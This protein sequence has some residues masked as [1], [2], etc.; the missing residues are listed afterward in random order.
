VQ[1]DIE[2]IHWKEQQWAESFLTWR[3]KPSTQGRRWAEALPRRDTMFEVC[4]FEEPIIVI[5]MHTK[6]QGFW[7]IVSTNI[8]IPTYIKTWDC[9]AVNTMHPQAP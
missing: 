3:M 4:K 2:H 6:T 7:C 9:K 1:R 8:E 5:I